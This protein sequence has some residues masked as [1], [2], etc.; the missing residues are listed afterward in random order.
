MD[1]LT[2]QYL[3]TEPGRLLLAEAGAL[4]AAKAEPVVALTRL[5]K[6][7]APEIA[8]AAWEM[9][10]SRRKGARK[11]GESAEAMYF[12]GEA[13]EQ[14]SSAGAAAYHAA[15]FVEAGVTALT[16]LCGGVGGDAIAFARAGLQV[17][18]VERDPA[19]ALFAAENARALNLETK[20][21][22]HCA[23]AAEFSVTTEAVWFD[24]ARRV[25]KRRVVAPEDYS[26]PLSLVNDLRDLGVAHIGIKLAPGIDHDV[27]A[28]MD[29]GLEFLSD[30]GECKES[31]F[32]TGRLRAPEP[33][34]ATVLTPHAIHALAGTPDEDTDYIPPA[35]SD[36]GGYFYE[37]DPAVIRA[38]LVRTLAHDLNAAPVDPQIAYLIA[39]ELISTPFATA[40]EIVERFPYHFKTLQKALNARGVGRVVVKKRGVPHEPEAVIK[41]LKLKGTEEMTVVLTRMGDKQ[42]AIL[43]RR[44]QE[45]KRL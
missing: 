23:D 10:A 3:L 42:I 36:E 18:V 39:P 25:D 5:R 41:Q 13:L 9:A 34:R 7:A 6:T 8:A 14:A 33:V 20:I 16:D 11:F 19:R 44:V 45:E 27:A 30:E 21:T 29:A 24:P 35:S 26:P 38:H 1:L 28:Q 17:T 2:A 4:L 15:R 37:P 22:V 43:C 32:W 12:V 40:Y 31:L